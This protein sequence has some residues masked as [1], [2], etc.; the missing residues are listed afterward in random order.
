MLVVGLRW[1]MCK[2]VSSVKKKIISRIIISSSNF[3][4]QAQLL[5]WLGVD[6]FECTNHKFHFTDVLCSIISDD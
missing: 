3:H 1:I 2:I 6:H 4:F 5:R